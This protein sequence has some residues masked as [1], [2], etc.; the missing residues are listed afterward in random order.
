MMITNYVD[1]IIGL[2]GGNGSQALIFDEY[3]NQK[4]QL[5]VINSGQTIYSVISKTHGDTL[6]IFG[7]YY[8]NGNKGFTQ[9]MIITTGQIL[10]RVN[11]PDVIRAAGDIDYIGNSYAGFTTRG[12]GSTLKFQIV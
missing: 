2:T 5:T 8:D 12:I 11:F 7:A 4:R 1:S 3:G 10:W 6:W 9:K